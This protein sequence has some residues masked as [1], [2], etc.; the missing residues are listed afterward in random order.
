MEGWTRIY[1][2]TD[3]LKIDL[4]DAMLRDNGITTSIIN[5][6]DQALVMIGKAELYVP[7][8]QVEKAIKLLESS[9]LT[10]GDT[11]G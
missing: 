5:K 11:I 6:K 9:D 4:L 7:E 3:S 1:T 8:D 10:K 2:T